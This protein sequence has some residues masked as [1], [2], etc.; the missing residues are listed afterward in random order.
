MRE[1]EQLKASEVVELLKL[2][3]AQETQAV[4]THLSRGKWHMTKVALLHIT[5]VNIQVDI[6]QKEKH[7]PININIDQPVGISFKHDYCKYLFES[8]VT[9]F[10]PSVNAKSGGII[11]VSMPDRIDRIQRRN[12]YRVAVPENLNVRV[13]FWHRGYSDE[14]KAVPLDDYWQ[15]NLVDISAGGLQ[16]CVGLDQRPNFREGQLV[17]VQFTPMPYEQP[18][19]LEAQVRHMA[20]TADNAALCL[21]LQVIGLEATAEGREMLQRVCEV[22]KTYFNM[23][24][25][26]GAFQPANALANIE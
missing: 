9:G 12:Y 18:I 25:R 10:E 11:V 4:M 21:G 2:A 8:T 5:A 1:Q 6:T 14:A 20:P 15:G 22:V 3:A 16:I 24:Q 17:G 13:L 7:H 26:A 19:Q 23:N